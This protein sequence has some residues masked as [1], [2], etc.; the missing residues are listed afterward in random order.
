MITTKALREYLELAP[1]KE[2]RVDMLRKHVTAL[3]E[4]CTSRRWVTTTETTPVHTFLFC[5]ENVVSVETITIADVN[6]RNV[7]IKMWDADEVE[8]DAV[9]LAATDFRL[10]IRGRNK[11][12][13]ARIDLLSESGDY[14]TWKANVKID[15]NAGFD[16]AETVS[17]EGDFIPDGLADIQEALMVQAE[18]HL[19][20]NSDDKLIT[21][22][23]GLEKSS[24]SYKRGDLHEVFTRAVR[25]YKM[26][27]C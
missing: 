15:Y 2:R 10:L 4:E 9:T 13:H 12:G 22:I 3:W 19:K 23:Q 16:P 18:Y 11:E 8:A 24:T 21:N 1:S 7:I 6:V 26:K 20:R 17:T 25:K 27:V 14:V 5:P